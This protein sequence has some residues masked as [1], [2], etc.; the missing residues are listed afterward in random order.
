MTRA[1]R[2][3]IAL[4]MTTFASFIGSSFAI[5]VMAAFS[6]SL[7]QVALAFGSA[8]YFS[9]MVLGLFAASTRH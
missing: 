4:F 5:M 9:M 1:G 7:A 6:P 2:G 3:G 8:E